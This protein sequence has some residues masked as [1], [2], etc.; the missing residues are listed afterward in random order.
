MLWTY[1]ATAFWP[2]KFLQK[3]QLIALCRF[4]SICL[5]VF[6]LLPLGFSIFN[7]CH[8]NYDMSW[9]VS[10]WVHL[11]WTLCASCTWISVFSFRFGKF[12][13]IISS[14]TF[15]TSFCLYSPSRTPIMKMVVCFMLSQRSLKL[16][17]FFKFVFLIEWFPLFCLLDH[18]CILMYHIVCYNYF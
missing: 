6:L 15:L 14:N 7:F 17:S 9:C 2:A 16:F 1:C 12:S 8:F 10:V 18:L 3:N 13:A 4:P 11:V 5:F